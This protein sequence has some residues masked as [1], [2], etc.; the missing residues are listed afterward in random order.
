MI[1]VDASAA[2]AALLND[3][4]ARQI[5]RTERLHAP[6]LID[7]EIASALRRQVHNNRVAAT[8]GWH[9]LDTWRRLGLS[10]YSSAGLLKRIWA[11]RNNLS[12]YDATYVAL[13]ESLNCALVTADGR[14]SNAAQVQCPITIVPR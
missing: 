8:D 4:Q 6:H 7:S 10:R 12:A 14:L 13:A 9:A 2:V 11:L 5:L 3:G 1:V